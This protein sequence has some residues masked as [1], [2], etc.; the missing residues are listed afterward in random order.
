MDEFT[1]E[2]ARTAFE[3]LLDQK[4]GNAKS[5]TVKDL[6]AEM[7]SVWILY[8]N[9]QIGN[10]ADRLMAVSSG[11]HLS[12]RLLESLVQDVND[13]L[14]DWGTVWAELPLWEPENNEERA[15]LWDEQCTFVSWGIAC[16]WWLAMEGSKIAPLLTYTDGSIDTWLREKLARESMLIRKRT[17]SG[18]VVVQQKMFQ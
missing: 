12:T 16:L 18:Q 3:N 8:R 14:L 4:H 13:K 17:K 1:R 2:V 5:V 6:Q 10:W 9:F 7:D 11:Q 15:Q